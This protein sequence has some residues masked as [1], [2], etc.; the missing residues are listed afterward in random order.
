M[1]LVPRPVQTLNATPAYLF[2]KVGDPEGLPTILYD[3]IDTIFGPKAKEHEDVRALINAGHR[4][5]AT[6]GRCVVRG[7]EVFPE[8]WPSFCAVALAGLGQLPDTILSRSV[9][10]KMRR[11]A[12]GEAVRPYRERV[13]ASVASSI[14]EDLAEWCASIESSVLASFPEMPEGIEDRDADVWEALLAVA[15]AAGGDWPVRARAA[16][17]FLVAEAHESTPSL[18]VRLLGDLRV[19]FGELE[20]M[21]TEKILEAL[22]A[23]EEAPWSDLRGKPINARTLAK[24]LRAFGVKSTKVRTDSGVLQG[25]RREDLHDSW[26]RYLPETV[27]DVPDVPFSKDKSIG[28]SLEGNGPQHGG[29]L[30]SPIESG[31]SGTSGTELVSI[32]S[33]GAA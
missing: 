11:R 2:R 14:L 24:M 32:E 1:P 33:G 5:G 28:T 6:A 22:Y 18:N 21:A 17:Q 19:V 7:K 10:I 20:V 26:T 23:I 12:P 30:V 31:T 29:D 25:Y 27:P 3:E 4:R 13:E 8:D 16:A 15:D 9:V